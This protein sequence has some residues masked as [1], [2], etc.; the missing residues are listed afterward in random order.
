MLRQDKKER[1]CLQTTHSPTHPSRCGRRWLYALFFLLLQRQK[2]RHHP[3]HVFFSRTRAHAEDST[4][5]AASSSTTGNVRAA[6]SALSKRTKNAICRRGT[7]ATTDSNA[8]TACARVRRIARVRAER[9]STSAASTVRAPKDEPNVTR[10]QK[11]FVG[12]RH[13][14]RRFRRRCRRVQVATHGVGRPNR[15]AKYMS[16]SLLVSVLVAFASRAIRRL[17]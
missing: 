17:S 5:W 13:R 9:L 7:T 12:V 10:I 16:A 3:M 4:A 15:A 2:Q 14:R 8:W 1:S 11:R 6:S